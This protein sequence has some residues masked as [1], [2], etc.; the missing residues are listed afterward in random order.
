MDSLKNASLEGLAKM[1]N[2]QQPQAV[3]LGWILLNL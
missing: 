1:E 3:T 2:A